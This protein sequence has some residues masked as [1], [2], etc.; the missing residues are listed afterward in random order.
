MLSQKG[1]EVC[2][3][4][5]I[6]SKCSSETIDHPTHE[7]QSRTLVRKLSS[8]VPIEIH[9]QMDHLIERLRGIRYRSQVLPYNWNGFLVS[10]WVNV[11]YTEHILTIRGLAHSPSIR[12]FATLRELLCYLC[13]LPFTI[14]V[15]PSPDGRARSIG[16]CLSHL[17]AISSTCHSWYISSGVWPTYCKASVQSVLWLSAASWLKRRS[18]LHLTCV[19]ETTLVIRRE[20]F[21]VE[22]DR[23]FI[24]HRI[25]RD[26][27]TWLVSTLMLPR[28]AC[29]IDASR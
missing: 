7:V 16:Q 22:L 1:W 13:G 11:P 17:G 23:A 21:Q 15:W 19:D 2:P 26:C 18:T 14:S 9:H 6:Y 4:N 10:I 3:G 28:F 12:T 27:R 24:L 29:V 8:L 20:Q 25:V 5:V